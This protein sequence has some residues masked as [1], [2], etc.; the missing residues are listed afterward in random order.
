MLII[1]LLKLKLLT[2]Y[3]NNILLDIYFNKNQFIY[4]LDLL[5]HKF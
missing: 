3:F 5:I 4:F 2:L 1:I